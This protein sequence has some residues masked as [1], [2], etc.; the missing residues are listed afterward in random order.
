M[1]YAVDIKVN[2]II[3]IN[4]C[5]CVA[6]GS[7]QGEGGEPQSRGPAL[8][9]TRAPPHF[10]SWGALAITSAL[11]LEG[12]WSAVLSM[13]KRRGP[14]V[15]RMRHKGTDLWELRYSGKI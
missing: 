2:C 7:Q 4:F 8:R 14:T 13:S 9:G 10:F 6:P 12:W 11:E 3:V 5:L 15:R 1:H